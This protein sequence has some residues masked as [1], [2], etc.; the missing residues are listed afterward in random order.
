MPINNLEILRRPLLLR[1]T[2]PGQFFNKLLIL[3]NW[4]HL[5]LRF[6]Y[7]HTHSADVVE[8]AF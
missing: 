4:K 2:A 7:F 8:N 6:I 3:R 1:M 5:T